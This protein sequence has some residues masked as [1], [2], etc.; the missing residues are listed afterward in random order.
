MLKFEWNTLRTGDDVL[1][2]D[3]ATAE[4][5]LLPGVVTTVHTHKRQNEV[6]IRVAAK[7]RTAILWPARLA[8]HRA[9]RDPRVPCWRCEIF[10]A[11]AEASAA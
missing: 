3:P 1:V 7:G 8:V 9:P 10:R 4:A 11:N 6:G 5:A 2:H